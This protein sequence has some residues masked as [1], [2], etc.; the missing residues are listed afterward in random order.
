MDPID[1]IVL[2]KDRAVFF[3]QFIAALYRNTTIPFNLIIVD[4]CSGH[5]LLKELDS[6]EQPSG[7][8][9]T[10]IRRQTNSG[11][12]AWGEGLTLVKSNP[13]VISDPDCTVRKYDPCWLTQMLSLLNKYPEIGQLGCELAAANCHAF[14]RSIHARGE[15]GH[16]RNEP[17]GDNGEIHLQGVDT[18]TSLVR[19]GHRG[20]FGVVGVGRQGKVGVA[21]NVQADHL[22]WDE[23]LYPELRPYILEKITIFPH[24]RKS[25]EKVL[26]RMDSVEAGR[27]EI[28]NG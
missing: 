9:L 7:G 14:D 1:I 10:I 28:E 24:L 23:Y 3:K 16:F 11:H 27:Q 25:Y 4:N 6:I 22:G 13:Y 21:V 20:S 19:H 8:R 12:N 26:E 2:T 15:C 17:Y 5:E 18:T